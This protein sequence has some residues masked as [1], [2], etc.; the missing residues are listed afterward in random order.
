MYKSFLPFFL[1]YPNAA[2]NEIDRKYNKE[3]CNMLN[4]IILSS[5]FNKN[6]YLKKLYLRVKT[7][8]QV[9][10]DLMPISTYFMNTFMQFIYKDLKNGVFDYYKLSDIATEYRNAE[11]SAFP[12]RNL[13]RILS[14]MDRKHFDYM[15]KRYFYLQDISV[16]RKEY[17]DKKI[18]KYDKIIK[19]SFRIKNNSQII[20]ILAT[21]D[22]WFLRQINS[23]GDIMTDS[24]R[25][26]ERLYIKRMHYVEQSIFC[27]IVFII[28][29]IIYLFIEFLS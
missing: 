3:F 19:K 13:N 18:K 1:D 29:A 28:C 10:C 14:L 23:S 25:N 11:N 2:L 12:K 7:H 22:D 8:I 6:S 20:N 16:I 24:L 5:Y 4:G 26:S 17:S 21:M 27:L 9:D 15:I